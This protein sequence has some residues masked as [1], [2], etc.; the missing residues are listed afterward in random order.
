MIA[1]YKLAQLEDGDTKVI[2]VIEYD[3]QNNP[4]PEEAM[5]FKGIIP[6]K[7]NLHFVYPSNVDFSS[8]QSLMKYSG[9]YGVLVLNHS[10]L[11][12][13]ATEINF[14]TI[15]QPVSASKCISPRI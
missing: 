5:L 1:P 7:E 2:A 3:E 4:V 6:E 10:I 12:S 14:Y 8:I 9:Y 11:H 13:P 15:K